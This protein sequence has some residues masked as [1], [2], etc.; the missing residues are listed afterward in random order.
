MHPS[1]PSK[2]ASGLCQ[3]NSALLAQALHMVERLLS[4]AHAGFVYAQAVGPHLRHIVEHYQALLDALA[5]GSGCVDYDARSRNLR[6]Q[7][8]PPMTTAALQ[9]ITE[10]LARLAGDLRLTLDT[11]LTTRLQAG[12]R[13][14]L[15]LTVGTTLGRELLFLASHTVHHYALLGHYCRTAGV[16]MGHAFGK[17]PATIGFE[18]AQAA[19]RA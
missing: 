6:V 10:S 12:A 19:V 7:S 1:T 17:A 9:H 3:Y 14:E 2:S 16:D 11:P 15:E 18:Q 13:G 4:E 5:T 8:E